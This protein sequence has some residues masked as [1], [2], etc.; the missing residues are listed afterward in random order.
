MCIS[1]FSQRQGT[2]FKKPDFQTLLFLRTG[3]AYH[4]ILDIPVLPWGIR[5]SF[6]NDHGCP[7]SGKVGEWN[8]CHRKPGKVGEFY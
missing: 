6:S 8:L 4:L 3:K 5:K 7:K 2:V 1:N